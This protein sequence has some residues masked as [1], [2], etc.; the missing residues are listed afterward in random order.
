MNK[1]APR[2]IDLFCGIGGFSRG[3][4]MADYN[5]AFGIDNW[6]VALETFENSHSNPTIIK[7]NVEDLQESDFRRFRKIDVIIAG[8]PCQGFSMSG[9]RDS[10]DIR[11]TLFE[12]VIRVVKKTKP[13]IVVI[14]N[15]VGL[16]SMPAPKQKL[17]KDMICENFEQLGYEIDYKI[18]NAV[19]YGVPQ[20]RKRVI[21]I[22]SRIGPIDFPSATHFEKPHKT[23]DGVKQKRIVTVGDAIGNIPDIGSN[24]YLKP[25]NEFQEMMATEKKIYNHDSINHDESIVKRM[26]LVPQGGNWKD[27]P[28]EY[29]GVGGEHSNNYRRLHPKKPSVTLKHASKSMI[30]HPKYNRTLAVRE[31]ARLQSF[32][33]A[34]IL[35]GTKSEQHQQL[36]NAVPPLLGFAIAKHIKKFLDK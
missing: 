25:K 35:E 14:E 26:S 29:Y 13:K 15:V 31:V 2:V 20:A 17:V 24:Y 7:K 32:D 21:F 30:I 11:N 1:K 3:F 34:F 22:A 33:D 5:V 8:P 27:I 4:E 19:D 28:P 23:L 12:Q 10:N 18:L 16:L 9:K 6:Q 36:A